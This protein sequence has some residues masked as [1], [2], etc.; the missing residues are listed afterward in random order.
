VI[1][2]TSP[3]PAVKR[4]LWEIKRLRAVALRAHDLVRTIDYNGTKLDPASKLALG[5][6]RESLD[7]EPV[8]QEEKARRLER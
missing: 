3:T 4:L 8:V 2:E 5:S 1:Y 7:Q 6:L